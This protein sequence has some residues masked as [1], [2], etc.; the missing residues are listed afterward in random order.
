MEENIKDKSENIL[1]AIQEF[2]MNAEIL[3]LRTNITIE[4]AEII[5]QAY[6]K[7]EDKYCHK[8]WDLQN[9]YND[10]QIKSG[11]LAMMA[12]EKICKED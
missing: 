9:K 5:M 10:L 4:V 8:Y 7:G 2:Q 6:H 12:L 3:A 1:S 11:E